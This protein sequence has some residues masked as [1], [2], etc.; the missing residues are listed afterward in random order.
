M[1]EN[2]NVTKETPVNE[3]EKQYYTSNVIRKKAFPVYFGRKVIYSDVEEITID[4]LLEVL[5]NALITH[6]TNSNDIDYLWN[7]Y[8]GDQDILYRPVDEIGTANNT[9]VEN[10]ANEIVTFKTGY[11]LQNPIQYVPR[12]EGIEEEISKLN[13]FALD[14]QKPSKDKK[15]SDWMHI[16]GTGY[17]LILPDSTERDNVPFELYTLDPR[18]T[19][20]VYHNGLGNKVLMGVT[21]KVLNDGTGRSIYSGYTPT[22]YFEVD[23]NVI[24][25]WETHILKEV[26]IIEYPLN[27]GRIGAFELVLPLLDSINKT[28]SDKQNGL[29]NFIHSLLVFKNVDLPDGEFAKV[30]VLGGISISDI[31]ETKKA[32]VEYLT[33][34]LNQGDSQ[35]LIDHQYKQLLRIV[36]MPFMSM[37]GAGSSDNGIAVELRDGWSQAEMQAKGVEL[38]WRESEQ[39][40]LK[41]L[42]RICEKRNVLKLK[43]NE[44]DFRFDRWN[45]SNIST[46]ADVLI[47]MLSNE[48]VH[49]RLAFQA[50]DLFI[51]PELAYQQSMDWYEE[52]KD[53][54]GGTDGITY[55]RPNNYTENQGNSFGKR[56][57]SRS[58]NRE[59]QDR[60][61]GID[62]KSSE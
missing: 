37:S 59:W 32:D 17:R 20:V 57:S 53:D 8:K 3:E 2:N 27:E 7:Y 21:V 23:S 19:F 62:T 25:R 41:L 51:D 40:F 28:I 55:I 47:K 45:H 1:S 44:I 60:S 15:L 61:S 38:Q 49:P 36:G 35:T 43:T 16:A 6:T 48:K 11:L 34:T 14:E 58:E 12:S 30:K 39:K 10:H 26:P 9:I 50:S 24:T 42:L 13:N 5:G 54:E 22:H 4:N 52:H 33:Q 18:N 56:T 46:K 29:E 31:S